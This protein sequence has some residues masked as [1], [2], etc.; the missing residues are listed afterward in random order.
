ME[1]HGPD[2]ERTH[3]PVKE[4]R[5]EREHDRMGKLELCLEN[6]GNEEEKVHGKA[7]PEVSK[8]N[9]ETMSIVT[10]KEEEVET[11]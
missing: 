2:P 8:K 11:I 5:A 4:P 3:K 7:F 6:Y 10:K 1:T 9:G